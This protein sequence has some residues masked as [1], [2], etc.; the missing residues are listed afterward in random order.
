MN[1]VYLQARESQP[2]TD[3]MPANAF[4]AEWSHLQLT[5]P[6]KLKSYKQILLLLE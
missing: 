1:Q 6:F 4:G 2:F 3:K 5:R